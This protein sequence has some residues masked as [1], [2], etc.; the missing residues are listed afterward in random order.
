MTVGLIIATIIISV[1][2]SLFISQ[3]AELP[4]GTSLTV[5]TTVDYIKEITPMTH[6]F[7]YD[8]T[9]VIYS[10]PNW[11]VDTISNLG[12]R[13]IA[14]STLEGEREDSTMQVDSSVIIFAEYELSTKYFKDTLIAKQPSVDMFGVHSARI[15]Q[16]A[17]R[18]IEVI[19]ILRGNDWEYLSYKFR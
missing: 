4:D 15:K 17:F 1:S 7:K 2:L 10:R 12:G 16:L 9:Y 5:I 3:P 6:G 11:V 8:T 18:Q 14:D 19:L 13:L